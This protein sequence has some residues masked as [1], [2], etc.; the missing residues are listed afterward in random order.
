MSITRKISIATFSKGFHSLQQILLGRNVCGFSFSKIGV[1]F[2]YCTTLLACSTTKYVEEGEYLLDDVEIQVEDKKVSPDKLTE[3][4]RQS[5]NKDWL[6]ISKAGLHLYSLSGKDTSKKINRFL[7]K[8]G[9]EPVIF[10]EYLTEKSESQITKQ[11]QN[12]GYLNAETFHCIDTLPKKLALTYCVRP[13]ELYTINQFNTE[14]EPEEMKTLLKTKQMR[15]LLNIK[16]G[17]PFNASVFN[18]ISAQLTENFTNMGY[19]RLSKENFYFLADTSVGNHKVNVSLMY[20]PQIKTS[21]SLALDPALR[22]Y[23]FR[24]V[25]I[26]NGIENQYNRRR[27]VLN[28][29]E[30]YDTVQSGN[31]TIISKEKHFLRPEIL[32]YYV[33]IRP[34]RYFNNHIVDYTYS[35]FSS[36]GA[37]SQVGIEII[38]DEKDSA[39]LD[40]KIT[41]KPANLY[42]FRFGID[43]TNSAGDLGM[44]AYVS[45]QQ[46]NLFHGSEIFNIK[47]NGA[48]EHING[49]TEYDVKT[50]NYYE[51]GGELSLNI[52]RIL[53]FALPEKIKK[54][55]GASTSFAFSANWRKRPEYNRSFLSLDWKYSWYTNYRRLFHSLNLYNINYVVSPWTSSWFQKYLDQ[56]GNELLKES[57]K[58]QFITR[59]TYSITYNSDT[60]TLFRRKKGWNIHASF[61]MAG[62]M[63]TLFC[64][65]LPNV[66]KEE[67]VYKI[68]GT[69]YAQYIKTSLDVSKT[70]FVSEKTTLITH[71][72]LGVAI[73]FGNSNIMPYEQ[74][75]FA[76]GANTVRGWKTRSLGP[77][78]FNSEENGNFIT[79]TGDVKLVLNFEY[80]QQTNSFLEVAAFL[81]AGNV[82]TIKNYEQQQNGGFAFNTFFK[83]LGW[84]WGVGLRPNFKFII[85]RLDAGMQI[86]NPLYKGSDAWVIA[87]PAW[88]FCALH[89][90]I[91]Y[92]F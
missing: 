92:P 80:R 15:N 32:P 20:R 53:M 63:P 89:F 16:E 67:G 19:Y 35:S 38:P 65:I 27:R 73:P 22:R 71:L 45:F 61:D 10:D 1:L 14:I 52:P 76:G 48:F 88:K 58:D 4:L 79:Q 43:G 59:T 78:R 70:F 18:D 86:Y 54:Q 40:A 87:H 55:I 83:E 85:I 12:L 84:S 9:E 51:Y 41:L 13:N 44:A 34:N 90:A 47:L 2:F 49:N 30:K 57:Y 66:K 75:F 7:R 28:Q 31:I 26:Y 5:P 77:G 33:F 68:L 56:S 21:D 37:V 29:E 8:I 60:Y 24:N 64:A 25:T 82:W 39:L 42:N 69:P 36:L 81:D 50:D 46:K 74:R 11:M 91:G 72:G 23:K 3:Y 62:T 6:F 17:A